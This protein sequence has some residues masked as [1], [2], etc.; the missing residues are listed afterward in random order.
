MQIW[1]SLRRFLKFL[2]NEC[3]C[4]I[5]RQKRWDVEMKGKIFRY[6]KHIASDAENRS[7]AYNRH[8]KW[9]TLFVLLE[10]HCILLLFKISVINLAAQGWQI[11]FT[12]WSQIV[13]SSDSPRSIIRS[14][15]VS[16]FALGDSSVLCSTNLLS[17]K[18]LYFDVLSNSITV[19][20][21]KSKPNSS[22]LW[23]SWLAT[24][25]AIWN[26]FQAKTS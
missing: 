19:S 12:S 26:K 14:S 17:K 1:S 4:H 24:G 16:R 9:L 18:L 2:L 21:I 10:F 11:P 22:W 25:L 13:S 7:F 8:L 20:F 6:N 5:V 15:Y 3:S 23:L